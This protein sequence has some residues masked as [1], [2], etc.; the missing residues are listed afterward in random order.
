M[1]AD[2]GVVN[3][4]GSSSAATFQYYGLPSNNSV[5]WNGNN[6][7]RGTVYAPQADFYLKGGGNPAFPYDYMGACVV[8]Q[9]FMNG[10][11]KF[12]FDEALKRKP[13]VATYI[14]GSWREL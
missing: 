1:K 11:F 2:F 13:P 6:G 14:A 10:H 12:H 4:V 3:M 8:N 9:V 7:Y 5:T